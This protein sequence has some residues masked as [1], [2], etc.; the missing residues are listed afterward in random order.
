M[1]YHTRSWYTIRE[2]HGDGG[3]MPRR[4][5]HWDCRSKA[6][7]KGWVTLYVRDPQRRVF[8][9]VGRVCPACGKTEDLREGIATAFP[10]QP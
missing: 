10:S 9:R 8:V 4:E 7:D 3:V 6:R 5:A 1:V 2:M